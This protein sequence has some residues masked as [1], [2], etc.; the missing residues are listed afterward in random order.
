MK[1]KTLALS[2]ALA[3]LVSGGAALYA[4]SRHP[5]AGAASTSTSSSGG[6]PGATAAGAARASRFDRAR[7]P[8]L[9]HT[10]R[11][12][13]DQDLALAGGDGGGGRAN[14]RI[15]VTG[16]LTLAYVAHVDG[17]HRLFAE[18]SGA[19]LEL[20]TRSPRTASVEKELGRPF[21]VL[22]EPDG[23]VRGYAFERGLSPTA[24][25][26]LRGLVGSA[27]LAVRDGDAW[28]ADEDD[29]QGSYVASYSR[30]DAGEIV[31]TK[32]K[33]E[34]V[35]TM[36][37]LVPADE[38]A[39][40][41][42]RARGVAIVGEDGWAKTITLD[43]HK[44]ASMGA[45]LPTATT[46]V[47]LEMKLSGTQADPSLLGRF[48][49]EAE[50]L[51]EV[52]PFGTGDEAEAQR[53]ADRRAAGDA[54]MDALLAQ[55][56]ATEDD[57]EV[58][59]IADRMAARL[60]LSPG[61]AERMVPLAK[62]LPD[63]EARILVGALGAAGTRESTR[64]LGGIVGQKGTP[65]GV[66]AQAATQLAFSGDNAL[67]AR[68]PLIE[69]M[70]DPSRDVRESS[71]LALGSVA[72]DLGDSDADSVAE[73]VRRYE[74][75]QTDEDRALFLRAL[76]NSGSVELLPLARRALASEN[77]ALREAAAHALR[78]LPAGEA[79]AILS[80]VLVE[81]PAEEVRLATVDAIGYRLV[82]MHVAALERAVAADTNGRI[83]A[84]ISEV[85]TRAL[86]TRGKT[87]GPQARE[88][89]QALIR[90][91]A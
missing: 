37:S 75:A 48:E 83:R 84:A 36:T 61:E 47:R 17:K 69:G 76:G 59:A 79:D 72:R 21:Y 89:L 23:R 73:L 35:A 80:R 55:A 15:R 44:T 33:Y 4:T 49:R 16:D 87:L 71:A 26:I 3:T 24:Q 6:A 7:A 51:V 9:R 30:G 28:T 60:R 2:L 78:F 45:S 10:Y 38:T 56:R 20:G 1:K 43:E 68:E 52:G 88:A 29:V 64:A 58:G 57:K 62:T 34:K 90:K 8:G 86:A 63:R 31:K 70:G 65:S 18:L 91:A 53:S 42:T 46:D 19:T 54:T 50:G 66:R 13:F 32:G 22:A 14:V 11:A 82:E 41:D 81:D 40:I 12:R 39:A 27:Q 74:E 85:A 5:A 77:E 67:E 25:N